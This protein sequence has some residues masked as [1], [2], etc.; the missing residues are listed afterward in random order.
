MARESIDPQ[1]QRFMHQN[2][3][4]SKLPKPATTK[5]LVLLGG[6]INLLLVIGWGGGLLAWVPGFVAANCFI[7][8]GILWER[9]G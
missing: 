6:C 8:F 2:P 7:V 5:W 4:Q 3:P 9:Y 1:W